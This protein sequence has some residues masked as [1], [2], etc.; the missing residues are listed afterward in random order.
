MG[1]HIESER[2]G[3]KKLGV[4]TLHSY[5]FKWYAVVDKKGLGKSFKIGEGI[6]SQEIN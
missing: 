5:C 3:A 1:P 6:F 2:A 4:K